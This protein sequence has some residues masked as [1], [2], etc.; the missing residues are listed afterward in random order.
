MQGYREPFTTLSHRGAPL[1]YAPRGLQ[2]RAPA[3]CSPR[4]P[5]LV[6]PRTLIR[7]PAPPGGPMLLCALAPCS[8]F[9]H[10]MAT[11]VAPYVFSSA[12]SQIGAAATIRTLPV[13]SAPQFAAPSRRL[14]ATRHPLFFRRSQSCWTTQRRPRTPPLL[15]PTPVEE[16]PFAGDRSPCF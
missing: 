3:R 2:R 16:A 11:L 15:P 1:A 7:R 6:S 9:R 14:A 4:T 5:V 13:A 8:L 10:T 12:P